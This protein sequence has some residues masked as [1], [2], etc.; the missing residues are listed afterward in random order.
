MADISYGLIKN[1]ALD[2]VRYI[3]NTVCIIYIIYTRKRREHCIAG[4]AAKVSMLNEWNWLYSK[5]IRANRKLRCG[6]GQSRVRGCV[7]L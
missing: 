2:L 3:C 6:D 4:L 7:I 1:F 5:K